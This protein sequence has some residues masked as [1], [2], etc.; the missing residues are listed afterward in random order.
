MDGELKQ[1]SMVFTDGAMRAETVAVPT[2]SMPL[3]P[4]IASFFG[5]NGHDTL[6]SNIFRQV[7]FNIRFQHM[8]VSFA[9]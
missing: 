7:V 9:K 2:G 8:S 5:D 3:L 4:A 1:C 6:R